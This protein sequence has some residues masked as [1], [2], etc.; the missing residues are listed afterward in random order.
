MLFSAIYRYLLYTLQQKAEMYL[1]ALSSKSECF[2][3][4]NYI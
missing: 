4:F 3:I 2:T 1:T